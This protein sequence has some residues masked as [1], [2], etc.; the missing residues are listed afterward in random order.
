[1][2]F[3]IKELDE[4]G[5]SFVANKKIKSGEL[6]IKE[7]AEIALNIADINETNVY[8]EQNMS[9]DFTEWLTTSFPCLRDLLPRIYRRRGKCRL[10]SLKRK[11]TKCKI[12]NKL[13]LLH[14]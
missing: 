3:C 9:Q 6:I 13:L 7:K 14:C 5:K 4:R 12:R 11:F 1:M 2:N 10:T 8:E